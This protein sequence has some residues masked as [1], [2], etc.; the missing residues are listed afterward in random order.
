MYERI[1]RGK[2]KTKT[3]N[4]WVFHFVVFRF[5]LGNFLA[6]VQIR[7]S[8]PCLPDWL[9]A[10]HGHRPRSSDS[11]PPHGREGRLLGLG[12]PA[13]DVLRQARKLGPHRKIS[14]QELKPQ[15]TFRLHTRVVRKPQGCHY[16]VSGRPGELR[17]RAAGDVSQVAVRGSV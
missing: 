4:S 2:T 7:P 15:G 5:E 6:L 11:E 1:G 12:F 8:V 3:K 13:Q 9:R 16:P 10:R 17:S 14:Q